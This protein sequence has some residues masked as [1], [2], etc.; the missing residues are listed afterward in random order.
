M[1]NAG[2]GKRRRRCLEDRA[3]AL[4]DLAALKPEPPIVRLQGF[5]HGGCDDTSTMNTT[6]RSGS[7]SGIGA[8]RGPGCVCATG[9]QDRRGELLRRGASLLVVFNGLRL[10]R[11]SD[12]S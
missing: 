7:S 1:P 5:V 2:N 9:I 12:R 6:A 4:L 3:Q 10:R 8:L 11:N